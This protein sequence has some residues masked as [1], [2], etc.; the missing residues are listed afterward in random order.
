M[1]DKLL[2]HVKTAA[3]PAAEKKALDAAYAKAHPLIVATIEKKFPPRDMKVL[4][5]YGCVGKHSDFTIQ[6]PE[7]GVTQF[8]IEGDGLAVPSQTKYHQVFLVDAR[9]YAAVEAWTAAKT[10]FA[11]EREKRIEAYRAVVLGAACVEDVIDVW[12]E[13]NKIIPQTAMSVVAS[14][15]QLA[16]IKADMRERKAA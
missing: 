1:R 8:C 13:A 10:A 16:I 3:A 14:P 2:N 4:E 11:K 5:R 15:E 6:S 12:P 7:G 9:T